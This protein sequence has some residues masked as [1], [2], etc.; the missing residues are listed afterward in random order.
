MA[1]ST[2]VRKIKV[3]DQ[4]SSNFAICFLLFLTYHILDQAYHQAIIDEHRRKPSAPPL[5]PHALCL[6]VFLSK[7]SFMRSHG[8]IGRRFND[9]KIDVFFN[10]QLCASTYVPERLRADGHSLKSHIVRFTGCRVGRVLEKPWMIVPPGQEPNGAI[11]QYKRDG[12]LYSVAKQRWASISEALANEAGKLERDKNGKLTVLGDYLDSLAKLD[13]P[14]EVSEMQKVGGPKFGVIDVVVITGKG[15]KDE[16]GHPFLHEP[17]QIRSSRPDVKIE[18]D[19]VVD[20]MDIHPRQAEGR[21]LD[22]V[23]MNTKEFTG[24]QAPTRASVRPQRATSE[25]A[26]CKMDLP[27]SADD[28]RIAT[29]KMPLLDKKTKT[30]PVE[31]TQSTN[32][33]AGGLPTLAPNLQSMSQGAS[34]VPKVLSPDSDYNNVDDKFLK[35]PRRTRYSTGTL[36]SSIG[37]QNKDKRRRVTGLPHSLTSNSKQILETF[38]N[39]DQAHPHTLEQ[40]DSGLNLHPKVSPNSDKVASLDKGTPQPKRA[41]VHYEIVLDNKMTLEEEIA[42]ITTKASKREAATGSSKKARITRQSFANA[43]ADTSIIHVERTSTEKRGDTKG[44]KPAETM[45]TRRPKLSTPQQLNPPTTSTSPFSTTITAPT[46]PSPYYHQ[47]PHSSFPLPFNLIPS[48]T[49]FPSPNQPNHHQSLP[50]TPL[51]P[52][53]SPPP[54]RHSTTTPT[55]PSFSFAIT[56]TGTPTQE[57]QKQSLLHDDSVLT[58]APE[59]ILRQVRGERGGWFVEEGVVMGVR[60]LVG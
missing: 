28:S 39:V 2:I 41:R 42:S 1:L 24:A 57:M 50:N 5:I 33:G 27:R 47:H 48:E 30:T 10:G 59:G 13:M 38:S 11:R 40:L 45:R 55:D 49:V 9:I 52:T 37:I 46:P 36:P 22:D 34:E 31:P 53:P 58:F 12:G 8:E 56:G 60:F 51:L 23:E 3:S 7:F 20:A 4:T 43:K 32:D 6:T 19:I 35:G 54:R 21:T 26:K 18:K 15:H 25:M 16:A 44:K 17:K 14:T 29:Q